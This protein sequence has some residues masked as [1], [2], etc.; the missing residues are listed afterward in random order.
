MRN[1]G[2]PTGSKVIKLIGDQSVVGLEVADPIG[3]DAA[4][5]DRLSTVSTPSAKRD[6]F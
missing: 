3:L 2:V 5:F 1:D 4:Q 6:S